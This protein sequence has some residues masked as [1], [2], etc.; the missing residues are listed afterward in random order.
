MGHES[1]FEE[2]IIGMV[3][4]GHPFTKMHGLRNKFVIV[5]GRDQPYRPA[6]DDIVRICDRRA[7]VGGD[8]LL[9]IGPPGGE[10]KSNVYNLKTPD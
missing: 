7:G 9:V 2:E 8:E 3:E 10:L 1:Q 4:R 5:D 6:A